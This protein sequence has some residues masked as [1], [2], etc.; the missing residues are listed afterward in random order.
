MIFRDQDK[1][2]VRTAQWLE[3]KKTS[4]L[5]VDDFNKKAGDSGKK[6][7]VTVNLLVCQKVD[8]ATDEYTIEQISG[9]NVS[10]REFYGVT[11]LMHSTKDQSHVVQIVCLENLA[12]RYG[13]SIDSNQE[14]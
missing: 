9:D 11:H 5:L 8:D 12:S 3:F 6:W 1:E 7:F 10:E 14:T 4:D 13:I 2:L